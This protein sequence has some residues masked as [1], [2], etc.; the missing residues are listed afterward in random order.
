MN[1]F[2]MS[3]RR[4][5]LM[6]L[7]ALAAAPAIGLAADSPMLEVLLST[8]APAS[9]TTRAPSSAMTRTL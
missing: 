6:G 5:V 1:H 9:P 8:A 2:A 3:S 4:R 7:S